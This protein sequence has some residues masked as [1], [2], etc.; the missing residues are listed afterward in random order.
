MLQAI[1]A[2]IEGLITYEVTLPLSLKPMKKLS[3]ENGSILNNLCRH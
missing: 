3:R 1:S 2:N